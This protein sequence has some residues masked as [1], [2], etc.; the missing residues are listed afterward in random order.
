MRSFGF[1]RSAAGKT[2][3]SND[4]VDAWFAGYTPD[5]VGVAWVGFDKAKPLGLTGAQA[6]LPMW[7]RFMTRATEGRPVAEFYRPEDIVSKK[8]DPETGYLY[9]PKCPSGFE[10]VF[11]KGTEPK[12]IC[13]IHMMKK[14]NKNEK[15]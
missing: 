10:E 13:P 8:I 1:T 6:A 14:S 5:L 12:E 2:G 4:N 9:S 11:I 15:R 7:A 3:T